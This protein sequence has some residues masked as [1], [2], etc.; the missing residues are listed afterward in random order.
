MPPAHGD[1]GDVGVAHDGLAQEVEAVEVVQ[2]V[3]VRFA[4]GEVGEVVCFVHVMVEAFLARS[5]RGGD[6]VGKGRRGKGTMQWSWWCAK[7]MAR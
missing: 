7:I 3:F 4:R 6:G 1:K 5:Q 2:A